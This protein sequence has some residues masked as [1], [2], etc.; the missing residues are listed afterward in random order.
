MRMLIVY[1]S[2][3]C[4]HQ[5]F[6]GFEAFNG[7][8]NRLPS[9]ISFDSHS[10]LN[11]SPKPGPAS[12]LCSDHKHL[13]TVYAAE[14]IYGS[15][16]STLLSHV[17]VQFVVPSLEGDAFSEAFSKYALVCTC[18]CQFAFMSGSC[19]GLVRYM[20]KHDINLEA[21]DCAPSFQKSF[22]LCMY[23]M[24]CL[25]VFRTIYVLLPLNLFFFWKYQVSQ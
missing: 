6:R 8:Q 7:D 18:M 24:V 25:F 21:R 15:F 22:I 12:G 5:G 23:F 16:S 11:V 17:A 1:D 4:A 9:D 19:W 13:W 2:T 14:D 3:G 20:V 10:S